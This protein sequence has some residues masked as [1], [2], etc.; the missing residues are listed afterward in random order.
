M[1]FYIIGEKIG[2]LWRAD[3]SFVPFNQMVEAGHFKELVSH[4]YGFTWGGLRHNFGS[5]QGWID[6]L[7][8][9][10]GSNNF[11]SPIN[12]F[13]IKEDQIIDWYLLNSL[14]HMKLTEVVL[15]LIK[16]S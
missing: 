15:D 13:R 3:Y 11:H 5:N 4:G 10:L 16:G 6:V 7:E 2:G 12:C 9:K 14:K 1:I 8:I